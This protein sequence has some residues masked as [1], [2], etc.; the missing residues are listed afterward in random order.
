MKRLF[1][2]TSAVAAAALLVAAG[3]AA[4]A[5]ASP[6]T[7]REAVAQATQA[8]Y[9]AVLTERT[10]VATVRARGGEASSRPVEKAEKKKLNDAVRAACTKSDLESFE[11]GSCGGQ[12][13]SLRKFVNCLARHA[14]LAANYA[15]ASIFDRPVP[16]TPTPRPTG[17]FLPPNTQTRIGG[18]CQREADGVT[19]GA[20]R[21]P[22]VCVLTGGPDSS[23]CLPRRAV[24]APGPTPT[25]GPG[26]GTPTPPGGTPTPPGG[27]TPGP[28]ATV[29][30]PTPTPC[31]P[32]APA[33]CNSQG[34][35]TDIKTGCCI[36]APG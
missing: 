3:S 5:S 13:S 26:G 27:P 25:P 19:W 18:P 29:G 21:P 12:S 23:V 33:V 34:G 31:V 1:P 28:T 20:C 24:K 10:R 8:Y 2:A 6:E 17:E 16:P 4:P 35:V 30:G 11:A 32:V 36:L 22:L 15:L 9:D 7:C 14:N